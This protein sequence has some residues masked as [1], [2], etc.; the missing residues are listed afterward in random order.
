MHDETLI[1]L[2]EDLNSGTYE[3]KIFLRK[4]GKGVYLAKVWTKPPEA[5]LVI[6]SGY[7]FF[8]IK[9]EAREVFV[10]CVLD[11]GPNNL[12]WL[13]HPA[14]RRKGY[15]VPALK[16]Y[17]LP[18]LFTDRDDQI[19]EVASDVSRKVAEKA[20]FIAVGEKEMRLM[21][22]EVR[23][24]SIN[25]IEAIAPF[26]WKRMKTLKARANQAFAQLQVIQ[27]EL[28]I[29]YQDD[30]LAEHIHKLQCQLINHLEDIGYDLGFDDLDI[31]SND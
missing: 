16:D 19:V 27:D 13:V 15:L 2:I 21:K 22:S 29:R 4:V 17:I 11:M 28:T 8:F 20:G 9:D 3:D 5:I 6:Q 25:E 10:A 14:F 30:A 7:D 18:Y 1:T 12:H 23:P 26:K 31:G 24:F